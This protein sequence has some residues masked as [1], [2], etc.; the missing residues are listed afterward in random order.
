MRDAGSDAS[1]S[2]QKNLY[3]VGNTRW[4]KEWNA[5]QRYRETKA[6]KLARRFTNNIRRTSTRNGRASQN[7]HAKRIVCRGLVFKN[8][9][10]DIENGLLTKCESIVGEDTLDI[11][12]SDDEQPIVS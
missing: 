11:I 10:E 3:A 12:E 2:V 5:K 8:G 9:I 4:R 7:L 1:R 6:A